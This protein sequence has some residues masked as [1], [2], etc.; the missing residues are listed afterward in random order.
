M[1]AATVRGAAERIRAA[2]GLDCVVIH[3]R[4]GAAAATAR[5]ESA[6]FDGPVTATPRLSTGAGDHFNSGFAGA[7]ALAG[8]GFTLAECL[9]VGCATSGA[10]VRD[11]A[12][13]TRERLFE[14]LSA[15]P[16]GP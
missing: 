9:A 3:P 7:Q 5:G 16:G 11:A 8:A 6:W 15:L 4:E 13:P 10:Y 12:S 2:S 14:F 1:L